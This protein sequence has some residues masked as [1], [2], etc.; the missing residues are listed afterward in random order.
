MGAHLDPVVA[1]V[2]AL[3]HTVV[4]D[5]GIAQHLDPLERVQSAIPRVVASA[6]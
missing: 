3:E 4:M 1:H 5:E 6:A 2:E